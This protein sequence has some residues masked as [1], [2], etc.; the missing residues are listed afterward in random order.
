MSTT[1]DDAS[2]ASDEES[3]IV[4]AQAH[5]SPS[6]AVPAYLMTQDVP[7]PAIDSDLV[8][9]DSQSTVD[10]FTNPA[11]VH[12]IR[13]YQKPIHVH[14]N[15]GTMSTT[16]EADFGDTP[17]YFNSNGIANVL[18]LYRLGRKFRVTYDSTDRQGVF[19]VHTAHSVVEFKPT[20]KGLHVLN[21]K[22]NPEAA[23]LLVNDAEVQL[24]PTQPHVA[25]VRTNFE[26]FSRKQV[27]GAMAARRLM[28]M[29]ATPS[30]RDF[31]G[32]VRH[33]M[34]KDCPITNADITNAHTIFGTDLATI[35][36]K[37]VRRRPKR[38]ITDYVNIPRELVE[39]NQRVTLA[40]DVMFVNSATLIL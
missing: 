7:A 22:D 32:K 30:P 1:P 26:G 24:S 15:S 29:V 6:D 19:Q 38:V 39:V 36:G 8:L 11:H 35:R 25:T 5:T 13:P 10:L 9:L 20:P 3:V 27:A 40:A 21:L 17:V 28:G 31:Q 14:C 37:T 16:S 12:N 18:S 23:F 4:L 33:N 34:L 2:V